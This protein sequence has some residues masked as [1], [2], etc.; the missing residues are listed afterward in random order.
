MASLTVLFPR[1]LWVDFP[2]DAAT[3]AIEDEFLLGRERFTVE[4]IF[5]NFGPML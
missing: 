4:T 1:P 3:F 2:E 5:K